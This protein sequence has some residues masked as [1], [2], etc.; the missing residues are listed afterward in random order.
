[1][2][3]TKTS[4]YGASINYFLPKCVRHWA[5]GKAHMPFLRGL[6]ISTLGLLHLHYLAQNRA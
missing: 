5:T 2:K 6:H 4:K 1:M 3:I